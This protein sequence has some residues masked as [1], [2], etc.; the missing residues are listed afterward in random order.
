MFTPYYMPSSVR[1]FLFI[2]NKSSDAVVYCYHQKPFAFTN[3]EIEAGHSALF[4]DITTV[5]REIKCP[6]LQDTTLR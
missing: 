4:V 1:V 2:F 3:E 5:P 6:D